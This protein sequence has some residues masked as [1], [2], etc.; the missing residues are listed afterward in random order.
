MRI[1]RIKLKNFA[2]I[3][4]GT[5][6]KEIDIEFNSENT[7]NMFLAANGKGKSVLMSCLTPFRETF[8]DRKDLIIKETVGVKELW[9]E[10]GSDE[11]K[12][13]HY[14]EPK[15][16]KSF[17]EKNGVE[18]NDNGG[19]KSF[20]NVLK[21][22][23]NLDTEY[24]K[25]GKLGAGIDSFVS[26][27]SSDRK[28]YIGNF[29]PNI[30][31]VLQAYEVA[32]SN[33]NVKK[34][35]LKKLEGEFEKLGDIDVMKANRDTIESEINE[36]N[37]S[38]V[39]NTGKKVQL[40][41]EAKDIHAD[42]LNDKLDEYGNILKIAEKEYKQNQAELDK[43]YNKYAN[44]KDY[45]DKRINDSIMV[46]SN[47]AIECKTKVD[48]LNERKNELVKEYNNTIDL[49]N[50]MTSVE[51]SEED[52]KEML[53]QKRDLEIDIEDADV[54]IDSYIKTNES[55]ES[56]LLKINNTNNYWDTLSSI[57]THTER[58][59]I[60]KASAPIYKTFDEIT[61]MQVTEELNDIKKEIMRLEQ[62]KSL[63]NVLAD[64]PKNCI[65]PTCAFIK[66]ALE[67]QNEIDS[68]SKI[69]DEEIRLAKAI[70]ELDNRKSSIDEY[71][72]YI[73]KIINFSQQWKV[74]P[75]DVLEQMKSNL[76]ELK[77][78]E[79]KKLE[80]MQMYVMMKD[81]IANN[82]SKLELVNAKIDNL[83]KDKQLAEDAQNKYN[84]S[85]VKLSILESEI[86]KINLEAEKL[87]KRMNVA[88]AKLK[89]LNSVK[90]ARKVVTDSLEKVNES[91][92]FVTNNKKLI[93]RSKEI[94]NELGII[95]K[96][97][98]KLTQSITIHK[99]NVK[100]LD[101]KIIL[102]E[103]ITERY[104]TL[105][106]DFSKYKALRDTLD[107]K[108]GFP[109]LFIKTYLEDISDRVNELLNVA[110]DGAFQI[111]FN[112]TARDFLIEVYKSDGTMLNDIKQASQ[113]ELSMTTVSLSLAIMEK[114]IDRYNILYLDEVDATLSSEN[115]RLFIDIIQ[116]QIEKMGIEQV[117][118]ISHNNEYFSYPMNL[119][120]LEGHDLDTD[121]EDLMSNKKIVYEL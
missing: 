1:T 58:H 80:S 111:K 89:I 37:G 87:I 114:S 32:N 100:E 109:V 48:M 10:D 88:N 92:E 8:D 83:M 64:R 84:D 107:P 112:I 98:E 104:N 50:N 115:R 49:I 68:K 118:I 81:M 113:G 45:D 97:I 46:E 99:S 91:N 12:I 41:K 51:Y 5:G 39:F 19:V 75:T 59:I 17:I 78:R 120:L 21:D 42:E 101:R 33:F 14:Y 121:D 34:K 73:Q 4:A 95:N 28:K 43:L 90:D 74:D 117:F 9:L 25:I 71:N 22:E 11:Y 53:K 13:T 31:D 55:A 69:Y 18:L 3:Y 96:E 54:I 23:L 27:N 76:G 24:I 82:K 2:G 56:I 70:E 108:Q 66:T 67:A 102:A 61:Y 93:Q 52:L 103:D 86:E 16:N 85:N 30:D 105:N 26:M 72:E 94:S 38:I 110:Y 7:M 60:M 29:I 47:V 35:E 15:N 65:I 44:L 62:L 63:T 77:H 79:I 57:D 106:K 119:V 20:L 40:E 36:L 116:K 6:L